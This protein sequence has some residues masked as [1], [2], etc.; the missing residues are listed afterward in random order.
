MFEIGRI[1]VKLAGRDAGMK[2]V[3]ID[4]VDHNT[5]LVDGQ[6][7]RRKCNVKHLEPTNQSLEINKNAPPAEVIR[8]LK[9]L[10]IEVF[11]KKAK[12]KS[13]KKAERP[14]KARK[15]KEKPVKQPVIEKKVK[16]AKKEEKTEEAAVEAVPEEKTEVSKE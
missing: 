13:A 2:C 5:V 9:E 14:R 7:R 11:E 10:G 16:K 4:V 6:T 12:A 15:A 8:L 1:C 3:I